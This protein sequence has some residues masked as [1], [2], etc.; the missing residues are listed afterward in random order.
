MV[1]SWAMNVA[2]SSLTP[3]ARLAIAYAPV[4][5]RNAFSLLLLFDNR[6]ASIIGRS[7]EP[8]IAQM[9][10][11]WWYDALAKPEGG[12]PKG[13]PLLIELN[14]IDNPTVIPAMQMVL[15]AWEMLLTEQNWSA[16]TLSD[17]AHVRA[18]AIFG[19][20]AH[21]VGEDVAIGS[22]GEDWA[23]D[24]LRIRFGNRFE[25]LVRLPQ[26]LPSK[27]SLRPLTILTLATQTP[28]GMRML[29]HA[30]TGQ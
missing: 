21:W 17:F 28:S 25:A 15:D 6:L 19:T 2:P 1:W 29:W 26:G 5:L 3:P 30:L 23:I 9:K 10:I 16:Q 4:R 13:E 12:R 7:T 8:L 20:Y 24:D 14:K 27:R 18:G 11:A 22:F